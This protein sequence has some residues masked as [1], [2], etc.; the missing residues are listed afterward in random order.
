[1]KF[2]HQYDKTVLVKDDYIRWFVDNAEAMSTGKI[3]D[4]FEQGSN[5]E[6]VFS[7]IAYR[8]TILRERYFDDLI[9]NAILSGY[10]QLVLL[11]AGFDTRILRLEVLKENRIRTVEVDTPATMK[12]KKEILE[13]NFGQ[14]EKNH[15]LISFDFNRDDMN[16]LFQFGLHRGLQTICIWQGVS[17]YLPTDAVSI[18]LD[19]IKAELPS[20]TIL[21]FDCCTPLMLKK[22]D[23]IPGIAF[24]IERLKASGEPYVFGM[25][26]DKMKR[27]LKEKGYR[28]VRILE[29]NELEKLYFEKAELP[30]RM[31]YVISTKS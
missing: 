28:E 23:K 16:S 3:D 27:W 17:Y 6:S 21:G 2:L 10:E 13:M 19:F 18:V 11:G 12:L 7:H 14:I 5:P 15:Y 20:E 8:Y 1:M 26:K 29:Q 9:E 25:Y 4:L 24:N 30:D 22:N 31:W